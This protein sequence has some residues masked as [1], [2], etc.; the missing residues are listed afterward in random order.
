M[1]VF[2]TYYPLTNAQKSIMMIEQFYPGSKFV[3]LSVFVEL[4]DKVDLTVL[5]E[6]INLA[7]LYNDALRIRV[8][9]TVTEQ[10]QHFEPYQ[11][12]NFDILEFGSK[13]QDYHSFIKQT[14]ETSFTFYDSELIYFALVRFNNNNRGGFYLK[15]HHIIVD[16]WSLIMLTSQIVNHYYALKSS[17]TPAITDTRSYSEYIAKEQAYLSSSRFLTDRDYWNTIL[18]KISEPTLFDQG[19]AKS[20]RAGRKSFILDDPTSTMLK[21]FCSARGISPFIL[22]ASILSMYLWKAK[23]KEAIV[24]GTTVLNRTDIKDKQTMGVF[25]NNLPFFIEPDSSLNFEYYLKHLSLEWMEILRHSRYPYVNL[26]KEYRDI[27]KAKN[28]L[29]DLTL[30]FLTANYNTEQ[31]FITERKFNDEEINSLC[32]SIH[33]ISNRGVFH[34]DYDY[35]IEVLTEE[36][37][38]NLHIILTHLLHTVMEHP[39]EKIANY[40]LQSRQEQLIIQTFNH[41]NMN[42]PSEKTILDLFYQQV[43]QTPDQV[44]LIFDSEELTYIQLHHKT[45]QLAHFLQRRGIQNQQT[46]GLILERSFDLVIGIL[47]ILK[48]GAAYLPIDPEYPRDRID[49]MV[50]DSECRFI[51]YNNGLQDKL[52]FSNIEGIDLNSTDVWT[53]DTHDLHCYPKPC[54][55]AYTIY[56]SGSTGGPKGVMIEHRALNNFVYAMM[57]QIDFSSKTIIS[58]TTLSFDIFFL[59]TI[60]PVL[61]GAKVVITNKEERNNPMLLPQLIEQHEVDILQLTPSKLSIVLNNPT[62]LARLSTILVGGEAFPQHLLGR[63][64]KATKANIFNMYG[65]TETTIWSSMKNLN[66]TDNITIGQPVGNTTFHILDKY[67]RPLPIGTAGEIYIS[68]DGLARGY[69]NR[70][71]LTAERFLFN[72][73]SPSTRMYRTGDLGRWLVTGEIE[74]LGRNDNQVKIR[75]FRIELNE[76]EQYLISHDDIDQGIVTSITDKNNRPYLCAYLTGPKEID[77]LELRKY[78]SQYLPDYMLPSRFT[79]LSHLPLTPNG[80]VNRQAL[81]EPCTLDNLPDH[82]YIPPRDMTEH[83]LAQIWSEVLHVPEVGID[84]DFFVLGGDSLDILEIL[85]TTISH[86]WNLTAQDFYEYPTIRQLSLSCKAKLTKHTQ[87]RTTCHNN[88]THREHLSAAYTYK[89]IDH[90]AYTY[91]T[92]D[93][94]DILLTG[95]T[96]FLGIHIL[97]E[98]LT[99][100]PGKIYCL[101]REQDPIKK[102]NNMLKFYFG[103]LHTDSIIDRVIV[104]NGDITLDNF[105]LADGAYHNLCSN[106]SSVIHSASLVKHYGIYSEFEEINVKGTQRVIDFCDK[107]HK[108]LAYI[109]T[110]SIGSHCPGASKKAAFCETDL[111]IGQDYRS[112][113]YIR[114]KFEAES[115]VLEAVKSGL[116]ANIFRI[117]LLTG[118]FDDGKFQ[119]NITDNAFYKTLKSILGIQCLPQNVLDHDMEFT[120]VDY[121]ARALVSIL[122]TH[123]NRQL[124]FHL[125]NHKT[126]KISQFIQLMGQCGIMIKE[127][128]P[129]EFMDKVNHLS[130]TLKG[131]EVISGLVTNIAHRKLAFLYSTDI[132][133]SKSLEFLNGIGFQWPN[134]DVVYFYKILKYMEKVRFIERHQTIG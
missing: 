76:I 133:S 38:Q 74:Y 82:P 77:V 4:L 48:A 112:N 27:H 104:L 51:L 78:L 79:W 16:A 113:V 59:E 67:L 54:D 116:Q 89:T 115:L 96:G 68:G 98:L 61:I 34:I 3:N 127:A 8:T 7:F 99:G 17:K 58:V 84:D 43:K 81:P 40:S 5:T 86:N 121:C 114:S 9:G 118:R 65:P 39:T 126:V 70:P 30:T 111:D 92:I 120:P 25:F 56:T 52:G 66:S 102:L 62:V 2:R 14:S 101:V 46:V 91:K 37:I 71:E 18:T 21:S 110:T 57:E 88:L 31:E 26:L 60:L 93:H 10:R 103:D 129:E 49:Y 75:G 100:F 119:Y 42:Y 69:W 105:G 108:Y 22:F 117:G 90:A 106:V 109:S 20:M 11:Q 35:S 124:V 19:K 72:P 55:L 87:Q 44:A 12:K 125:H 130:K 63:L 15:C 107:N 32:I 47:G 64:K 123:G 1:E 97:R 28:R 45:N 128:A 24:I 33:D 134:L 132:D 13:D 131:K 41:T 53:E 6:A 85:S 23:S 94:G 36:E 50:K 80:K 83:A 122:R 29:F 95:G 73:L